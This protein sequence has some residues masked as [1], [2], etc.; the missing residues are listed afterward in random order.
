[1]EDLRSRRLSDRT[2]LQPCTAGLREG[3]GGR[4]QTLCSAHQVGRLE[5]ASHCAE[6]GPL[7]ARARML[8]EEQ[9]PVS[10]RG[11]GGSCSGLGSHRTPSRESAACPPRCELGAAAGRPCGPRVRRPSA[12]GRERAG[13]Q[14]ARGT[15]VQTVR[16]P[17]GGRAAVAG[18]WPR[19]THCSPPSRT[20][21][22]RGQPCPDGWEE[23]SSSR[24][25]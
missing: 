10:A 18:L 25:L 17:R 15:W 16:R 19:G 24:L 22:N 14:A 13:A 7:P 6:E 12:G 11:A 23:P 8:A 21:W 9:V 3:G 20:P 2:S 4:S 5:T 1:M